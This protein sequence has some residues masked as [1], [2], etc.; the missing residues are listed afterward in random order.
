MYLDLNLLAWIIGGILIFLLLY[1]WVA[2]NSFIEARNKVK[3]DFADID[4]QLRR[5]AS[6]IE[7][8]ASVWSGNMPNMK[9]APLKRWQRQ[10]A[11]LIQ[12]KELK[13]W[14]V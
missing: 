3:T 6:L 1:L 11:L 14:Q 13:R 12:S 8:L 9:K 5:R 7:N 2:Y 4:V 10:E